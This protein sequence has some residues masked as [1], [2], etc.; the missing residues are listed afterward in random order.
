M[1]LYD[2]QRHRVYGFVLGI[3]TNN[4]DPDKLGR[5]KVNYHMLDQSVESDWC[6]VICFYAGTDRGSFFMP[7]VNDEVVLGFEYGDVNFPF[8]IG[9]VYNGKD[10]PP[11][12]ANP[13]NNLKRF[14]SRSGHELTFDDTDG[15]EKISLIDS[16]K[17]NMIIIDVEKDKI[18]IQAKTGDM[19][20]LVPEGTINIK[21]KDLKVQTSNS[22]KMTSDGTF[23]MKA[24]KN[25]TV[26]TDKALTVEAA[27]KIGVESK[28]AAIEMK[29]ST[30]FKAQATQ[31][32]IKASASGKMEASGPLTIKGAVV[33]IN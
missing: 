18:T 20:I 3:V 19:D 9:A 10:K 12:Q 4:Q 16:S 30:A 26:K 8:V 29:A 2:S 15:K 28:G 31:T 33:N 17:N 27:Q 5:V 25:F 21:C 23:D 1:S 7:E 11:V 22:T 6:R 24:A 14:R 32:E 13:D